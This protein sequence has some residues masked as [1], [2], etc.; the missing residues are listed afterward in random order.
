M[1]KAPNFCPK[2]KKEVTNG[3][4]PSDLPSVTKFLQ[5]LPS[6]HLFYEAACFHD[7]DYHLGATE[8]H[9]KKADDSFLERMILAV[10][11]SCK[12]YKKPWYM[13]SA[14]RNWFF[15]KKFGWKFFNYKGCK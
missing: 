4:G 9:R 2:C 8:M 10:E 3:V 15:V 6:S 13:L 7:I 14:Y 11:N 12:W 1:K 5:V